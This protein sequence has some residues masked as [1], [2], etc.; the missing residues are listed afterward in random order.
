MFDNGPDLKNFPAS[1]ADLKK[2]SS[3]RRFYFVAV[4]LA[5]LATGVATMFILLAP[6][7]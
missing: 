6:G 1:Q 2:D 5:T 7:S 3:E 4:G